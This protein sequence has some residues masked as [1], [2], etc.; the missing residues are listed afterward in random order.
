MRDIYGSELALLT[1]LHTIQ[2][3]C[4]NHDE[5]YGCPFCLGIGEDF[6]VLKCG[7]RFRDPVKWEINDIMTWRAF[8]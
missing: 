6:K 4:K 3:E 1:A 5:C 8:K 7:I 2:D